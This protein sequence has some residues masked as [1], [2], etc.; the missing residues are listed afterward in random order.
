MCFD[1]LILLYVQQ[2][3]VPLPQS[4]MQSY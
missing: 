4:P 3:D 2:G 1:G